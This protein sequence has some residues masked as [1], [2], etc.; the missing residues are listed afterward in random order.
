MAEGK[1]DAA[2][3]A[4]RQPSGGIAF[5]LASG[6]SLSTE[7]ATQLQVA[8][9]GIAVLDW[10]S[11]NGAGAGFVA[12][13]FDVAATGGPTAGGAPIPAVEFAGRRIVGATFA[14]LIFLTIIIYGMWV[15]AG[16]VAEKSAGSWSC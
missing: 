10:T 13:T 2:V 3:V 11:Q 1:L 6:E 16:V 8:M 7:R 15:A 9:F 5:R 4:E 12:P 14:V